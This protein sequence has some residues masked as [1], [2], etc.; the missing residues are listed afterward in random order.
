MK[1][2]VRA[3]K[4][5][6]RALARR[7]AKAYDIY[8][9]TME[10][11]GLNINVPETIWDVSKTEIPLW[12]HKMGGHAVVKVPYSNAGQGVYLVGIPVMNIPSFIRKKRRFTDGVDLNHIMPGKTDGTVSQ[13]YAHR[14]F[15][16]IVR[17]FDYMLDLHT[18]SAGRVNSY[19]I[20]ADMDQK[21]TRNLALQQ[22]AEVIV[23]NPPSD[24][25]LRGAAE[26]HGISAITLEVGNPSIFQKRLIRS[27]VQGIHNTLAYL[28]MTDDEIEVPE[29]APVICQNSYWIYTDVG[30]LLTVHVDLRQILKKG[31]RVASIRNIFGDLIKEYFAPE[32]GIVIGKSVSPVNQSG[33][34]I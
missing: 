33:G 20:R 13:V 15:E 17:Q 32:A 8:N 25:T 2:K 3:G 5:S 6:K 27:G 16:K 24:G 28:K 1:A 11:T 21:I 7:K 14:F 23:N 19:Y 10:G 31:E 26:E 9:S 34:R 4:T 29:A 22:C 30:G 12:V 18:A